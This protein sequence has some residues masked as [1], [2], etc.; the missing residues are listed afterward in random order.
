MI[1]YLKIRPLF[2]RIFFLNFVLLLGLSALGCAKEDLSKDL[3]YH[4]T[5]IGHWDIDGGGRLYFDEK[6]FSATAGCNTLFGSVIIEQETVSFSFIATTLIGCPEPER[7]REEELS[8]LFD[9]A[10]LS[11]KIENNQAFLENSEGQKVLTLT[12][13]VNVQ[14]VNAWEL[15]SIK[16]ENGISSSNTDIDTGI[17]FA[18]DGTVSVQT[19]CNSGMG[20]YSVNEQS[21]NLNDLAFTEMGCEQEFMTRE[22][23]FTQALIQ[24]NGYSVLRK[25][26][27][28]EKDGAVYLTFQLKE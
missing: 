12:R 8:I 19:A 26:L 7:T 15:Q 9:S 18:A 4:N 13:P 1:F 10:T 20:T 25:A 28:L 27:S 14:L 24:V 11:Y 21:L 23:E 5:I 22:E 16:T 2:N 3:D 17:T 6:K